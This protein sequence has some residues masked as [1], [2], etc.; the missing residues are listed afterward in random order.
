MRILPAGRDAVLVEVDDVAQALSLAAHARDRGLAREV[1]PG[2]RT[3]LLDGPDGRTPDLSGWMPEVTGPPPGALV[4]LPVVYD[5]PDLASVARVWGCSVE[6]VVVRH[7]GLELVAAFCGFAPGFAYLSGLPEEL[8][9]PRLDTPR[10]R[11][12]A[13]SVGLAGA[14]CGVYPTASPGGWQLIGRTDA[15]LWDVAAEPPAL[16]V[17][18]T[19]VRFEAVG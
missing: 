12:P 7:T 5:G 18:G 4:T 16:I 19:R 10:Q 8:A 2:A 17:P 6:E 11:V 15:T 9:V 1:V 13:G 3:V 14:W